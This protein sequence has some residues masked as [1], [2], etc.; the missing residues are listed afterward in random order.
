M[1]QEFTKRVGFFVVGLVLVVLI[2]AASIK[3]YKRMEV[4]C[5]KQMIES[6]ATAQE[7]KEI[8]K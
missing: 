4:D 1:E 6:G 5:L 7:A 3:G 2:V 8:C